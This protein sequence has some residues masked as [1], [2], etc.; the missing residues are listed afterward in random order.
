M[1]ISLLAGAVRMVVCETDMRSFRVTV[2]EKATI[3]STA[4]TAVVRVPAQQGRV[5]RILRRD[6]IGDCVEQDYYFVTAWKYDV[7]LGKLSLSLMRNDRPFFS[8]LRPECPSVCH[9]EDGAS[10]CRSISPVQL[11][12]VPSLTMSAIRGSVAPLASM[13]YSLRIRT[14]SSRLCH[15][16]LALGCLG[17]E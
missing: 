6:G 16:R 15:N 7:N 17:S 5:G 4:F 13:P 10:A 11:P 2:M 14:I 8:E 9:E 3:W 1:G 12:S